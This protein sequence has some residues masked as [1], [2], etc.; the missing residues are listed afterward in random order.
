MQRKNR[1]MTEIRTH[2]DRQTARFFPLSHGLIHAVIDASSVTTVF[3]VAFAH[4]ITRHNAFLLVVLYNIIAFGGQAPLGFLID[5]LRM[6]RAGLLAGIVLTF[7]G[8]AL[9][10]FDPHAAVIVVALGNAL[11]HVGAGALSLQVHPGH[12]TPPGIFVA[13]GVLGLWLG[14]YLG[15][16]GFFITWPF[17]VAL[18]ISFAYAWFAENPPVPNPQK[19]EKPKI[20]VAFLIL[21]LLLFSITV[22]SYVGM[23]GGYIL[24]K[25]LFIGMGMAGAAFAGKAMGGILADRFGWVQI[26]VGALLVSAPLVAFGGENAL[27]LTLGMFLFQMTMPVTLVAVWAILPGRP[28]F[29]FGLTCLALILGALPTFTRT[30]KSLYS[31]P[32]FFVL[33]LGAAAA[34]YIA[35]RLLRPHLLMK[36]KS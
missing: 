5:K 20:K 29:A 1:L 2:P 32:L 22:R 28:A 34:I 25:A 7:V 33:I 36:F 19:D 13:P 23:G 18:S 10:R 27:M 30:G 17:F 31:G 12:A 15:K 9:L 8:V 24:P 14:M 3:A 6:H 11:F 35:L 16:N 21:F 26:T 4:D